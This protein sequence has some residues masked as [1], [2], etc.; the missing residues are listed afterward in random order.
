MIKVDMKNAPHSIPLPIRWGEGVRLVRRRLGEGGSTGEGCLSST[1]L[2]NKVLRYDRKM[3]AI[4]VGLWAMAACV[5]LVAAPYQASSTQRMAERLDRIAREADPLQNPFLNRRAAEI[6]SKQLQMALAEPFSKAIIP[7]LVTLRYKYAYELLHAGESERAV[8]QF[9]QL[10]DFMRTNRVVLSDERTEI[11]RMDAAVAH[12]RLGEQENCLANHTIDSCL[13]PIQPGGYH[14]LPR[15]SRGA[16]QFLLEQLGKNPNDLRAGWLL[17]LA[18]MTLGEHPDKVPAE[19]LIPPKVFA[20]EYEIKRFPDVARGLGLDIND[21]AGSA[22]LDDLDNDGFLDLMISGMGL[23]EQLR[24]FRNNGD[25]TFTERTEEAG[26]IGEFGGLNMVQADYNNDGFLDIFVLRGAWFE[27]Q[28]HHPNSLLRNNGNGTFDDV[29]GEAGLLSFRP[30][31]TGT[32]FDFNNDGWIDLFI[33]NESSAGDTNRC[34][35]FRNNGDGTFS[36]ISAAAGIDAIG[37]IKSAHSGDFNNDGWPDLYISC[38]GQ[39]NYL[40]RNDGPQSRDKSPRGTWKF[41][42]VA[43]ELGV[44]APVFSFPSFF[45]DYDNDGWLDLFSCGYGVKNVGSVAADYLGLP[46]GA[47]RP[48]LYRNNG[49]GTFTDVT[50]PAGLYRV[51]LAM[52]GNFG[53][54]DND[55]FLDIYLGT[56]APDLSMLVPNRMLRNDGGRG[57]QDVTTSGGF[58]HLQKGHGI[59][60]GDLDHDGDQ[61]IYASIGGAYEGDVYFNALFENPGHGNDWLKLKLVGVK[62]NRAAIGAR[63][64]VTVRTRQGKR[65][66]HKTVNSGGTFGCSPL[67]QEIGLG[68]AASIEN[69]EV[70]WPASG[71]RQKLAG[72]EKNQCYV[73]REGDD[74]PTRMALKT[75]KFKPS[76]HDGHHWPQ[77]RR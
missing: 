9:S 20:S 41:T 62:S 47:E 18:L 16:M 61:D 53:D 65:A 3:S 15:G 45:F 33:G 49:N 13:V 21:L 10:F 2:I 5:Q 32:W 30:T 8:E 48:R 72:L 39:P 74:T 54:L 6:F 34:E 50:K 40:Y 25:G 37:L 11:I 70:W 66:I 63:I 36:E 31:Q 75:F 60:F 69:V 38:R 7:K 23:R 29:T 35:L 76:A 58:G 55:G 26:L 51:L 17:N 22:V 27:K 12:L 77:I 42:N 4:S 24:L 59:A 64:Q 19:F 1:K 44:A 43:P 56:G 46:H 73:I 71:I 52:A 28:G 14:K 68:Q 57:F 67:R